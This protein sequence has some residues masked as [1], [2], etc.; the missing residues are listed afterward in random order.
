MLDKCMLDKCIQCED[1]CMEKAIRENGR[2]MSHEII[3]EHKIKTKN[4]RIVD[5]SYPNIT[6]TYV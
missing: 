3:S 1:V 4:Q 5:H 6:I 2:N